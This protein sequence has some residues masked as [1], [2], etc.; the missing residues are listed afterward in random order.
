MSYQRNPRLRQLS[1]RPNYKE[2]EDSD[3]KSF[4]EP[5]TS[6][7]DNGTPIISGRIDHGCY[8][9]KRDAREAMIDNINDKK[10]IKISK[11]NGKRFKNGY[12]MDSESEEDE[13]SNFELEK[14]FYTPETESETES[15]SESES[16]SDYQS[17]SDDFSDSDLESKEEI[18]L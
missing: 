10:M 8:S 15:E 7:T 2:P 11:K 14:D 12:E 13:F 3:L 5:I 1:H 9:H 6:K 17:S 4:I 18:N 16:E